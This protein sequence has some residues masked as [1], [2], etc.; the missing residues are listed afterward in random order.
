MIA[1]EDS[2]DL[3]AS[4]EVTATGTLRTKG[5]EI[6]HSGISKQPIH[7]AVS[8]PQQQQQ[9]YYQSIHISSPE[10]KES[11]NSD[12]PSSSYKQDDLIELSAVG[13]GAC[14]TVK[15]ALHIPT[16]KIVA[17]KTVSVFDRE[18]RKQ[19]VS[20]LQA[21]TMCHSPYII[22]FNG[23]YYHDGQTTL[24]LEYMNRLSL[25]QVL[26]QY[27]P[28]NE[29]MLQHIA[30]Q[31]FRGLQTM[32]SLQIVHRD[33]K[34]GNILLNSQGEVKLADFGVLYFGAERTD[35]LASTYV[36]TSLFMSPERVTNERY[37][38]VADIWSMGISLYQLA[39]GSVPYSAANGYWGI[40]KSIRDDPAPVLP[41]D[42]EWSKEFRHLIQCCC[43]KDPT[44]RWTAE[45]LLS[46]PFLLHAEQNWQQY[47]GE[48]AHP[49]LQ[50]QQ[51]DY[52]DLV[53]V[54]DV[55]LDK[56]Y[57]NGEVYNKKALFQLS[58]LE[59]IAHELGM[60]L[61]QV[62]QVFEKRYNETRS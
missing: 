46:H 4:Y 44:Q 38:P 56:F 16:C 18:K 39:T 59:R 8:E 3:S 1:D 42:G 50:L 52:N 55:L 23:A 25:L 34:P 20:E 24:V 61:Q 26:K 36:G 19:L 6:N 53:A 51:D 15:R 12:E 33:I 49:T 62:Q 48:D 47:G 32:H 29:L 21:L 45:Q 9:Q 57:S 17:L 10:S 31:C 2:T 43:I 40:V 60:T 11:N 58:R 7:R 5:F 30:L 27:G 13:K 54:V 22:S 41:D 35:A 14:S 37:G 28:L